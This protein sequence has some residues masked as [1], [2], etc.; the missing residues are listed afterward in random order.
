MD[1][2]ER[3]SKEI[4][5]DLYAPWQPAVNFML[6][7]RKRLAALLLHNLGVFPT[8]ESECLEI[9]YGTIGWL[10]DLISWGIRESKLHGIELDP[11]RARVAQKLLPRADLRVGDATNLPWPEGH[12]H[13]VIA[14][15]VFTSILD[16]KVRRLVAEEITR[17]L[18]PSGVLLWYDFRY[19]NPKNPGVR[20][21]TRKELMQ[22]FPALKGEIQSLTLAPPLSRLIAP[23]SWLLAT[24]LGSNSLLRT[25]LLAVL[26]KLPKA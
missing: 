12:F 6:G 8:P 2:Y 16:D 17:V 1:E 23:R 9:G 4:P 13:L 7:E 18:A 25:H 19:N 15:T 21:V 14:S 3:R 20:K 11:G 5:V 22:L 10:G 26:M 24:V